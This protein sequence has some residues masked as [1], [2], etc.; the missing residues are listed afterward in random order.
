MSYD[1]TVAGLL[2]Q[3]EITDVGTTTAT[4]PSITYGAD[5][6]EWESILTS[7]NL[8]NVVVYVEAYSDEFGYF[9]SSNFEFCDTAVLFNHETYFVKLEDGRWIELSLDEDTYE[10][11]ATVVSED[12]VKATC[13]LKASLSAIFSGKYGEF[14]YDEESKG[15]VAENFEIN[16]KTYDSVTV[17]IRNGKIVGIE[18]ATTVTLDDQEAD[19]VYTAEFFAY[20]IVDEEYIGIPE[21]TIPE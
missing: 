21:F 16:G 6:E 10:Y 20:G 5:E 3:V 13:D 2:T 4:V 14:T 18:V 8:G 7:D 11:I 15:L 12:Y 9:D 17:F 1:S 19:A